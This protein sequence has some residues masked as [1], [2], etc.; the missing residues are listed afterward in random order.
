MKILLA[1]VLAGLLLTEP[2]PV[3]AAGPG[4]APPSA[5]V[6][7]THPEAVS[8]FDYATAVQWLWDHGRRRQAAFWFYVFQARTRPWALAD[9]GGDGA[10]ALRSALNDEL[11]T[12]IN[13]WVAGDL[14]EWRAIAERAVA[15]E[16]RLPLQ[17]ERPPGLDATA[18]AR[19][20]ERSRAEYAAQMRSA[21][22]G[23]TPATFA[24]NRRAAGLPVGPLADAGPPLPDGW[25]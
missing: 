2:V 4:S 21:F 10:A 11:G 19:L 16:R 20:V 3:E 24:A 5:E 15:Y 1:P 17:P 18:W 23:L 14:N 13:G 22:D 12:V 9:S 25:R 8:P 7:L 6:V